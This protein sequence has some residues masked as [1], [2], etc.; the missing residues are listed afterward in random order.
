MLTC[1][2]HHVSINTLSLDASIN[3]YR[4]LGFVECYRYHDNEVT[5]VH[6]LGQGGFVELFCYVNPTMSRSCASDVA[7]SNRLGFD[8]FSMQVDDIYV[9]HNELREYRASEV[10]LGRTGIRYFFILDPDGNRIEIVSDDR[11]LKENRQ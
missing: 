8:H 9:A 10:A 7:H 11:E 4:V 2:H 1:R 5:I 6:L 3:F